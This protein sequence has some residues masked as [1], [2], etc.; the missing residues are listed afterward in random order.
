MTRPRVEI[1]RFVLY[2]G[3]K[4]NAKAFAD[5]AV[6]TSDGIYVFNDVK[7]YEDGG[8]LKISEKQVKTEL[9]WSYAYLIPREFREPIRRAM[10][11]RY[12]EAKAG[13]IPLGV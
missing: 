2:D 13:L 1:T 4:G 7:L 12:R 9:G 3:G 8:G 10:L 5:V 11:N 6:R